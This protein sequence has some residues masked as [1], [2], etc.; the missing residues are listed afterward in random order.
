[1]EKQIRAVFENNLGIIFV[2]SPQKR[3]VLGTHQNRRGEAILMTTYNI[4]FVE[5]YRNLSFNYHQIPS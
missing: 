2:F 5:N 4:C 1:M 3:Y